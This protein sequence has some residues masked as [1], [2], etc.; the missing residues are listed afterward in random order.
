[1]NKRIID[2]GGGMKNCLR[3]VL[4][5]QAISH[6]LL[7]TIGL[8]PF[9]PRFAG[10]LLWYNEAYEQCCGWILTL[11]YAAALKGLFFVAVCVKPIQFFFCIYLERNK[12]RK[13]RN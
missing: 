5:P 7:F 12:E 13:T 9:Y 3:L 11:I 6:F 4:A 1:M 10:Y 8:L 2:C